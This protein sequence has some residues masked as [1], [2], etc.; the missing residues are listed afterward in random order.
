MYDSG[1]KEQ[2]KERKTKA[3]LVREKELA[4]LHLLL[5]TP[6]GRAVMWRIL[7]HCRFHT[8]GYIADV[9]F[10][11]YLGGQREVAGWLVDECTK[12]DKSSYIKMLLEHEETK[13]GK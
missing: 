10:L 11:N 3:Q 9:Q 5:S 2:V 1:D 7:E 4:D 13:G 12:A 6:N 8:Y